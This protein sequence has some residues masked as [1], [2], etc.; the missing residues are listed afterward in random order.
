MAAS[1]GEEEVIVSNIIQQL[2]DYDLYQLQSLRNHINELIAQKKQEE[3]R[4]V[5]RVM[6]AFMAVDNFREEDYLKAVECL[7]AAAEKIHADEHS[8]NKERE[9]R[10]V[11]ERVPTS[12]YE[13]WFNG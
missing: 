11:A 13:G 7:A 3:K 6:D 5:W 12:E 9:L 2:Q 1:S 4:V 10:I 8:T